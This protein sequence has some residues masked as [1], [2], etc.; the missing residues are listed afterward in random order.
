MMQRRVL[1]LMVL[2]I[3]NVRYQTFAAFDRCAGELVR[4]IQPKALPADSVG[5][6]IIRQNGHMREASGSSLLISL[7]YI[8][9]VIDRSG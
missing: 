5:V 6:A 7:R 9:F 8:A 3:V 4:I 2:G 1:D